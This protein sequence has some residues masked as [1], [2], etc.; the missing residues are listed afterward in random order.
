MN[1]YEE[2]KNTMELV[3]VAVKEL[4]AT[5]ERMTEGNFSYNMKLPWQPSLDTTRGSCYHLLRIAEGRK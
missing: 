4:D 1:H 5:V 3:D 2:I